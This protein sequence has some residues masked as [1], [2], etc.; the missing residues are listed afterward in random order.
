MFYFD[1]E[2]NVSEY[3][4]MAEGFDGKD[5]ILKLEKYLTPGASVLELG[6]GPGTDLDILQEKYKATG[7]DLSEV[8]LKNYNRIKPDIP[9]LKLDAVTIDTELRFDCIYSNKVLHHLFR[10]QLELSL[11]R[12]F[13]VVHS[14]GFIL[15]S[16]WLGEGSEDFDGLFFQYY[17]LNELK[18]VAGKYFK[19]I[20]SWIYAEME[21]QDSA[22]LILKR[23]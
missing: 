20:D 16:F 8:F 6:M 21:P 4:A 14:G 9:L 11:K 3:T 15:H 12:Q 7:S 23:V 5:L 10:E 22:A 13:D 1:D 17:S 19:V 2:K 18:E